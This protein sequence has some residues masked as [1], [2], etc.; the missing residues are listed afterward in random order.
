MR[1][2]AEAQGLAARS[3]SAVAAAPPLGFGWRE[4]LASKRPQSAD[5][6]AHVLADHG[7]QGFA[8]K[9]QQH[10]GL[11]DKAALLAARDLYAFDNVFT[12]PLHGLLR[13]RRTIGAGRRP[14]PC[15]P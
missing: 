8:Q 4:A 14:N 3:V 12:A 1:W 13:T 2:A 5:L 6:H 9:W 11:F 10:P 15:C 7:A